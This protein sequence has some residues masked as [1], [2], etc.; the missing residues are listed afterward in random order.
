[1]QTLKNL[2][3][4][5]YLNRNLLGS[6]DDCERWRFAD[7]WDNVL[8]NISLEIGDSLGPESQQMVKIGFWL[9]A[10][11]AGLVEEFSSDDD[12]RIK[13]Y[14][15]YLESHLS[16]LYVSSQEAGISETLIKPLTNSIEFLQLSKTPATA[17]KCLHT[18]KL[19]FYD[20]LCTEK[21]Q[22]GIL[23]I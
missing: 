2:I 10:I 9:A 20:L 3:S 19:G 17:H 12:D 18:L 23:K 5:C 11:Y 8:R 1:M 15:E 21:Y 14:L 22:D 6:L 13:R 16:E 4:A 7:F